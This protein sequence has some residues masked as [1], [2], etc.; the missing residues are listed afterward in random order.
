MDPLEKRRRLE[1]DLEPVSAECLLEFRKR[2]RQRP[3]VALV[4]REQGPSCRGNRE[5]FVGRKA[6]WS[7]Q[8]VEPERVDHFVIDDEFEELIWRVGR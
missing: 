2:S 8:C 3:V 5:T 7:T 4:H 1:V 6:G